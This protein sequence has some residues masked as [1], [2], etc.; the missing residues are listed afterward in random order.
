MP[1]FQA[2]Q[3]IFPH[4]LALLTMYKGKIFALLDYSIFF[5]MLKMTKTAKDNQKE[6]GRKMK[7]YKH[8]YFYRNLPFRQNGL[9]KSEH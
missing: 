7:F 4:S 5:A 2:S 3:K 9:I 8:P 1:V 6:K